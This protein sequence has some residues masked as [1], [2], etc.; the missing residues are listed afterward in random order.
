MAD[1][2][3]PVEIPLTDL[4]LEPIEVSVKWRGPYGAV[5]TGDQS[6]FEFL[7]R[8]RNP[9]KDLEGTLHFVVQLMSPIPGVDFRKD[10]TLPFSVKG[11][12]T[13]RVALPNEWL[14]AEGKLA[15][16]LLGGTVEG[17]KLKERYD[18]LA[19]LT[20]YERSTFDREDRTSW[21]TLLIAITAA[22]SS[23]FA[24]LIAFLL[25]LR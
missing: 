5:K 17:K 20:V 15:L 19:S 22:A 7:V 9:E 14:Y 1:C 10:C 13:A 24:A 21:A 4:K 16:S 12:E 8:N 11:G 25:F 3:E 6:Q 2:R 23:V 18:P